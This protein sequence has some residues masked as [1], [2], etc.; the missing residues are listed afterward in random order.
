MVLLLTQLHMFVSVCPPSDHGSAAAGV[1]HCNVSA[2]KHTETVAACQRC[3]SLLELAGGRSSGASS[4]GIT[5]IS[6]LQTM[7][8]SLEALGRYDDAIK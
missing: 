4:A 1:A 8:I 3:I 2:L 5:T 7:A 6:V